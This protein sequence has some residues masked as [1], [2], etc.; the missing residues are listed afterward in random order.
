MSKRTFSLPLSDSDR[1][2]LKMHAVRQG[3]SPNSAD[4]VLVAIWNGVDPAPAASLDAETIEG[5]R[6]DAVAAAVAAIEQNPAGA[7]LQGHGSTSAGRMLRA[8]SGG[9]ASVRNRR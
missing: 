7:A 2:Y 6:R 3:K 4:D 5:I 8:L 1:A 9:A